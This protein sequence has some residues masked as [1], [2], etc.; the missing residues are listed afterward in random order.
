MQRSVKRSI[1]GLFC[2]LTFSAYADITTKIY[3]TNE[4]HQ[5]LGT[6]TFSQTPY[7]VLITPDLNKLPP[8]LHGFHIHVNPTCA[9]H[10][11]AAG[12]HLDPQNTNKHAGP[13]SNG[14]L[15]DL[16][17]LYVNDQ[18]KADIPVFAPRLKLDDI[19]NHSIMIHEGGDNYSDNP[20]MGG[21]GKRIACG[22]IE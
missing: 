5:L 19:K 20:P 21:G 18:R 12:G 7:G 13:Y 22:V 16:P 11:M 3:T 10:G 14:H 6:V 17:A 15:G 9:D 8:G 1:A 4:S 2:F